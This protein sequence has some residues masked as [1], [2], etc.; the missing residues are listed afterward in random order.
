MNSKYLFRKSCIW[1]TFRRKSR[2]LIGIKLHCNTFSQ[3]HIRVK[4][5]KVKFST[6]KICKYFRLSNKI[7]NYEI[8]IAFKWIDAGTFSDNKIVNK[9]KLDRL[10]FVR[11]IYSTFL[12]EN[13]SSIWCWRACF[14]NVC[15][16][17]A[18]MKMKSER[19]FWSF[20][21]EC[22]QL[23]RAIGKNEK[24]DSFKL[25]SEKL[26]SFCLNW[27]EPNQVEKFLLQFKSFAV[28]W[29][30]KWTWKVVTAV[31]KFKIKIN[32]GQL[33]FQFWLNFPTSAVVFQR[34]WFFSTLV[35]LFNF[36][37]NFPT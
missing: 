5:E 10:I 29:K 24:L 27:T 12:N 11:M 20:F 14:R 30:F 19:L 16:S 4:H 35:V 28:V 36:S 22:V 17:M 33:S 31:G 34:Q 3:L 21:K 9:M 15:R 32:M 25:E 26:E 2:T 18:A 8:L 7:E 23:E 1:G 6:D 37:P 13:Q